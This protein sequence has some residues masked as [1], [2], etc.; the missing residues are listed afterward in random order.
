MAETDTTSPLI[1]DSDIN[2]RW[3]QGI[4]NSAVTPVATLAALSQAA[5]SKEMIAKLGAEMQLRLEQT[6]H[7]IH[8]ISEINN[9]TEDSGACNLS[10]LQEKLQI[11]KELGAN[12]DHTKTSYNS[13]ERSRLIENLNL[14]KK[15]LELDNTAA[16]QKMETHKQTYEHLLMFARDTEKKEDRAIRSAKDGIR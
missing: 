4:D 12:I 5:E 2:V 16:L 11:A 13:A 3:N 15:G 10:Q 7:L 6:H 9:L 8:V 14:T 1:V